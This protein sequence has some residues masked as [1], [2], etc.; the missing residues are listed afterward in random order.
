MI[1]LL[2][3]CRTFENQS[4]DSWFRSKACKSVGIPASQR[5]AGTTPAREDAGEL[6]LDRGQISINSFSAVGLRID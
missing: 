2:R 4:A 6:E 1:G 5:S 3:L